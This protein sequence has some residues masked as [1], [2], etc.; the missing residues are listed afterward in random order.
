M[1]EELQDV[2]SLDDGI[3]GAVEEN[4]RIV[5]I[6]ENMEW[7]TRNQRVSNQGSNSQVL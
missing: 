1:L 5:S 2:L 4:Q 7:V 6:L 3:I